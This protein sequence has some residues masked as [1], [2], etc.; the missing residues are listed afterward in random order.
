MSYFRRA[1]N[2]LREDGPKELAYGVGRFSKNRI[3]R[4]FGSLKRRNRSLMYRV[5]YRQAAPESY[6]VISIDPDLVDY[7]LAPRF[8]SELS[9]QGTYIR[10]GGWDQSVDDSL[11]FAGCYEDGFSTKSRVA[12]PFNNYGLYQS[13]VRHFDCGVPWEDTEFYQWLLENIDKNISRYS[14]QKEIRDRLAYIDDLYYDM[15][16]DGYKTQDALNERPNRTSGYDEVLV[17]VGRDG[18]FILDDGRHRLTLAKVL[19]LDRVPVRI[20]VR[21]SEWQQLRY[22]VATTD[23]GTI[24]DYFNM[25]LN[26]PDLVDL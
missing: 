17:N 9:R 18:R 21:H 11:V 22:S 23:S 12:I 6:R 3:R 19:G 16:T 2:L 7:I 5:K 10:D 25:G 1:V 13:C 24:S 8:Q 14:S 4:A 20:F 15:K 26:H